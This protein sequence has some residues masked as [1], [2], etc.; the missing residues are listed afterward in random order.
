VRLWS[1]SSPTQ[2]FRDSKWESTILTEKQGAF[3]GSKK[4]ESGLHQAI[5][6]EV[7]FNE[8]GLPYGLSTLVYFR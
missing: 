7:L 8:N 2:D 1:A 3:T 6:G 5:Y 4:T